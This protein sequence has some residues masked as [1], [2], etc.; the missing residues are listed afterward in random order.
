MVVAVVFR[1]SEKPSVCDQYAA[2]ATQASMWLR[3]IEP[4]GSRVMGL[5]FRS[6]E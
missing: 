3:E 2:R 5:K 4:P 6:A 1:W